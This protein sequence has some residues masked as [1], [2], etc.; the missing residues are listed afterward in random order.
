MTLLHKRRP[1]NAT[2]YCPPLPPRGGDYL[3]WRIV[4]LFLL[5]LTVTALWLTIENRWGGNFQFPT[6]YDNDAHYVLGMMKLVSIQI[7][8]V[9]LLPGN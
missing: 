8:S 1:Q 6:R 4:R 5:A 9:L 2:A 3:V 7:H